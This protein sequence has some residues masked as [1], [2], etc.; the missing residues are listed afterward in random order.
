MNRLFRRKEC[1]MTNPKRIVNSSLGDR[2]RH[3]AAFFAGIDGI[4]VER[5]RIK[6]RHR[7]SGSKQASAEF[8]ACAADETAGHQVVGILRLTG[9]AALPNYFFQV[10]R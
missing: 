9:Q 4:P 6:A 3:H 7:N 5:V 10:R 1:A 8:V 2:A